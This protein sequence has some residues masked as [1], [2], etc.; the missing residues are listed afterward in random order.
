M[1]KAKVAPIPA[2]RQAESRILKEATVTIG[3]PATEAQ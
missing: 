3:A 2:G 1:A